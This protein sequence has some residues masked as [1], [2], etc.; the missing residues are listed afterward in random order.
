V[1][2]WK[3]RALVIILLAAAALAG[4]ISAGGPPP[5]PAADPTAGT[6][7]LSS[8]QFYALA[9]ADLDGH[10]QALGQ[11]RGKLLVVNFWA[12][13]CAPCRKEIP[14]F[15]AVSTQ[16]AERG[17][18][19]VGLGIDSADNIARF[20]TDQRVPYPLLVA[21]TGSL[22]IMTAL[23]NSAMAL[24]FTLIVD[25]EGRIRLRKLGPMNGESLRASLERMLQG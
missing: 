21:G 16:Y 20:A 17:V 14:D 9:F 25:G 2:R 12:T 19:F 15:A 23:G 4:W 10:P 24:P 11:W 6:A 1:S 18:Q 7:A 5:L 13:W 22:P 3:R 8:E